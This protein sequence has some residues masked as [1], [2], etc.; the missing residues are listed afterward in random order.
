MVTKLEAAKIPTSSGTDVV[1]SSGL[2]D[3]V[4]ERLTS[5]E[6]GTGA[7]RLCTLIPATGNRTESR[8]RWIAAGRSRTGHIIVDDGATLALV[9]RNRSLLPAGVM[10]VDGKFERG[11]TISIRNSSYEIA[12]GV[13]N[14]D[15]FELNRIK[16]IQSDEIEGIL[17]YQYG[18]EAVHRNNMVILAQDA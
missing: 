13:S 11:D 8:K 7:N 2:S 9:A 5:G 6:F 1:I 3:D 17:G 14:Y 15:S 16:G 4:L 12:A 18:Q 10:R